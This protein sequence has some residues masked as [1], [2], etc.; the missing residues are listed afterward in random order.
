[1][2]DIKGRVDQAI[3]H[4]KSLVEIKSKKELLQTGKGLQEIV[5]LKF[6]K[7]NILQAI[8]LLQQ[9]CYVIENMLLSAI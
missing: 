4:A 9:F 7:A 6:I 3:K 1:M 5:T 8:F 2:V